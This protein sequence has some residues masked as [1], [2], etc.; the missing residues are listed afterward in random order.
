VKVCIVLT[1]ER[2]RE[3]ER[4][5]MCEVATDAT[6]SLWI[7]MR[8]MHSRKVKRVFVSACMCARESQTLRT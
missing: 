5:C 3:R 7:A 2:E 4:V 1:T 8:L 6:R